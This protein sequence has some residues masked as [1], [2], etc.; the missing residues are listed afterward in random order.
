M[1]IVKATAWALMGVLTMAGANEAAA[2]VNG[3]QA[4]QAA[5]IHEGVKS[6]EL[7]RREAARLHAEQAALRAEERVYRRDGVLTARERVDLKRDQNRA[8]RHIARQ[9]HD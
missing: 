6:G 1:A 9:K 7:T 5:R 4:R 8:S 3:R 2:T